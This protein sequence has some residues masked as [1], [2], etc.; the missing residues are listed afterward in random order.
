[1]NESDDQR[2]SGLL[3]EVSPPRPHPEAWA[4]IRSRATAPRRRRI[5]SSVL[6]VAVVLVLL[7]AGGWGVWRL[8]DSARPQ[9]ILVLQPDGEDVEAATMPSVTTPTTTAALADV[10]PPSGVEAVTAYLE[11]AV[12]GMR[13]LNEDA[14]LSFVWPSGQEWGLWAGNV[15]VF[16]ADTDQLPPEFYEPPVHGG[17]P[18]LPDFITEGMTFSIRSPSPNRCGCLPPMVTLPPRPMS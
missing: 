1:M 18:P 13:P 6:T 11:Y 16:P 17:P 3:R 7:A 12:T 8:L 5:T 4:R 9:P 15:E 2:L 10:P 14:R